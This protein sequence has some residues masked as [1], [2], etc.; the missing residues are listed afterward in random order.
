MFVCFVVGEARTLLFTSRPCPFRRYILAATEL[1]GEARLGERK[2]LG[3]HFASRNR[4][5]ALANE[6][7]E[8]SFELSVVGDAVPEPSSIEMSSSSSSFSD[9]PL[10]LSVKE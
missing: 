5:L 3:W 7:E 9:S 2:H 8:S 4:A 6:L 10:V 1:V